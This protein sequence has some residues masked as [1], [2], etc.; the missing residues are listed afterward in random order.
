MTTGTAVAATGGVAAGALSFYEREDYEY[1]NSK[2]N[3]ADYQGSHKITP[4][5][6]R[7]PGQARE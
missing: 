3:D 4:D 2:E 5:M 7:F 6:S 1:N